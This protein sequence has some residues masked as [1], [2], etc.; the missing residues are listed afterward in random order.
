MG[1]VRLPA[2]RAIDLRRREIVDVAGERGFALL[3]RKREQRGADLFGALSR[4]GITLAGVLPVR[5]AGGAICGAVR[6]RFRGPERFGLGIE[7]D[8]GAALAEMVGGAN[9]GDAVQPGAHVG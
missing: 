5:S 6:A 2:E 9:D 1:G 7:W 4:R 8:D 3:R